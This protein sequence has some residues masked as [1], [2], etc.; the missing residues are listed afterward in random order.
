[1]RP[2]DL[3]G[4]SDDAQVLHA[5]QRHST[6]LNLPWQ[7]QTRTRPTRPNTRSQSYAQVLTQSQQIPQSRDRDSAPDQI[8]EQTQTE[9]G[10]MTQAQ[11]LHPISDDSQAQTFCHEQQEDNS[12]SADQSLYSSSRRHVLEMQDDV[13]HPATHDKMDILLR[14]IEQLSK[15][16][17]LMRLQFQHMADSSEEVPP[18]MHSDHTH[19][20]AFDTDDP[21]GRFSYGSKS[22]PGRPPPSIRTHRP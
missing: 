20:S 6:R 2:R 18:S 17:E 22:L 5:I 16:Q 14:T 1:M 9:D 4:S 21:Y 15:Q 13:A 3:Q 12:C 19:L 10:S 7:R 8:F 11:G